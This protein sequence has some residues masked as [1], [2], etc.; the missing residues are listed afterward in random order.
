MCSGLAITEIVW[1]VA[2]TV[3]VFDGAKHICLYSKNF[4]VF[5]CFVNVIYVNVNVI[6]FIDFFHVFWSA[7]EIVWCV[8]VHIN[9]VQ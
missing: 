8:N 6:F 9:C 4:F 7:T 2:F 1:C 3:I 5:L